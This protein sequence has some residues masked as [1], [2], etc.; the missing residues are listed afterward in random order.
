MTARTPA[1]SSAD[2]ADRIDWPALLA[3]LLTVVLWAS[4]FV[5]IRAVAAE[6]SPGALALGRLLIGSLALGAVVVVRRPIAP[7]RR[8]LPFIVGS[9]VLWFAFYNLALNTGE[10]YVDAGTAAMLVNVG[11]ILIA[12]LGGLFLGEG[13]PPRLIAGSA[14]AF[15]GA[16]VIGLAT[17]GGSAGGDALLGIGLCLAAAVAYAVG[18]VL[19]KPAVRE[20]PALMVT[21]LACLTGAVV[22]L[23]FAADLVRDVSTAGPE[24]LG[25]LAYLGLFPTALAFTTWAF[26]LRRT[27]AGRLGSTTYLVPAIAIVLGWLVLREVPP[28]LAIVGGAIAIGGVVIARSAPARPRIRAGVAPAPR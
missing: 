21:W 11:P 6:L 13:F 23:P 12:V 17:S 10:R 25:W 9:G 20:V 19:Q 16:T 2:P 24:T 26:A 22:C 18:V 4:A 3:A 28:A 27:T 5:G 8:S 7:T 15:G 14:V 1:P